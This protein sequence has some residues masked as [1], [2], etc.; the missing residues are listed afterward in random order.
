MSNKNDPNYLQHKAEKAAQREMKAKKHLEAIAGLEFTGFGKIARLNREITITEKIDGTNAAVG[1]V[2]ET[3]LDD[4]TKADRV[5]GHR[6]YAQ[7]R[8]R[9]LS[10][11]DDNM[12]FAK[13]V[14]DNRDILIKTLGPGLHFGEYWGQGI[15]RG[16]GLT[17]KRFSLFNVEKWSDGE[18]KS[19]LEFARAAGC[20]IYCVPVLYR[21]PWIEQGD[22]FNPIYVISRLRLDGSF[23][24]P[25]FMK[26]EGIVIFHKASGTRLKATLEGDEKPKG[27]MEV[28]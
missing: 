26:P 18:G 9:L 8:T 5:V 10:P 16:Y 22:E 17:E 19:A 1:I 24:A 23:A 4:A 28:S 3:E 27:S 21:G 6:V 11:L 2:E 14:E 15:Q 12:G 25:G 20:A 7:S 13:W